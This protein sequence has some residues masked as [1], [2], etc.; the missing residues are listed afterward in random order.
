MGIGNLTL[1]I[2][3]DNK[4]GDIDLLAIHNPLV[5]LIEAEYS[6]VTPQTI[7][8][9]LYKGDEK[10]F[11]GSAVPLLDVDITHRVFRFI[12]NPTIKYNMQDFEDI[13]QT[14]GSL[15]HVSNITQEFTI[16][17]F[18]L[19]NP[20]TI[21]DTVTFIAIICA[22]QLGQLPSVDEIYNNDNEL[23]IGGENKQVYVYFY[24]TDSENTLEVADH[25]SQTKTADFTRNNCG[26]GYLPSTV[27]FTKT[28]TSYISKADLDAKV[29]LFNLEGQSYANS[30]G[31][32]TLADFYCDFSSWY[33]DSG[34]NTP[35]QFTLAISPPPSNILIENDSNK[36]KIS[37]TGTGDPSWSLITDTFKYVEDISYRISGD[38]TVTGAGIFATVVTS[39]SI[40]QIFTSGHFVF[41]GVSL[42]AF[43]LIL[44]IN[45]VDDSRVGNVI[46]DNILIERI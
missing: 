21:L 14:G 45:C 7:G 36:L 26:V 25:I 12:A 27:T 10:V 22:R 16:N 8:V 35:V 11:V 1:T 46:F 31:T 24:N 28:Y 23:I 9:E 29:L 30:H 5:F 37:R 33:L 19:D 6:G 44:G 2:T 3:Q 38:V 41:E 4:H 39:F 34:Y 20:T 18:D 42:G 40:E 17:V 15:I 43:D 32:C 13:V